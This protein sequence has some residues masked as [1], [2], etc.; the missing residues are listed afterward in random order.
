ML[1]FPDGFISEVDRVLLPYDLLFAASLIAFGLWTLVRAVRSATD[2][3]SRLWWAGCVGLVIVFGAR[4]PYQAYLA[5]FLMTN[6]GG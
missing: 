4:W 5:T 6:A 1:G 3:S 2:H